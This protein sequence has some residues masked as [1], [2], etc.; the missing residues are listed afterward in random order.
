MGDLT[1]QKSNIGPFPLTPQYFQSSHVG[2]V[3]KSAGLM[4]DAQ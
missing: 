1:K 4:S 3:L 2:G